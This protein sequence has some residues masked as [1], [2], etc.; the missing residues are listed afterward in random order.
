MDTKQRGVVIGFD[1]RHNSERFVSMQDC[2]YFMQNR[3]FVM[4]DK[5]IKKIFSIV[6][7]ILPNF[8]VEYLKQN[9]GLL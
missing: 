7:H 9:L 5:H 8:D 1:S 6:L 3:P 2:K 4:G